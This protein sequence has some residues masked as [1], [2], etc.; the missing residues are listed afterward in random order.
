MERRDQE[1]DPQGCRTDTLKDAQRTRFETE[2]VLRVKGV[3]EQRD[4]RE[5]TRQVDQTA[6]V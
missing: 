4:A 2:V 5:E 1:H 6:I 3:G